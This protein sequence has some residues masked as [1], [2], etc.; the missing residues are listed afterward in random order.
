VEYDRNVVLG[1]LDVKLEH[2]RSV[3]SGDFECQ[4]GILSVPKTASLTF[5]RK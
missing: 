4:E 3:I 5:K 1:Q 2:V